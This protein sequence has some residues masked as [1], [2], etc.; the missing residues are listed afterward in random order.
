MASNQEQEQQQQQPPAP[1]P[2]TLPPATPETS[3]ASQELLHQMDQTEQQ[4]QAAIDA[5]KAQIEKERKEREA[6]RAE[7]EK[8]REEK[9]KEMEAWKAA[10]AETAVQTV[11]AMAK[12]LGKEELPKEVTDSLLNVYTSPQ[13]ASSHETFTALAS[14][15]SE[16]ERQKQ[17]LEQLKA[18]VAKLEAAQKSSEQFVQKTQASIMGLS[19][20][21]V[22]K[23]QAEKQLQ[24]NA[25]Q[26][27]I[28]TEASSSTF[29]SV[30]IRVPNPNADDYKLRGIEPGYNV[31]ASF[32][33]KEPFHVK[34]V[35]RKPRHGY[36]HIVPGSLAARPETAH[37]WNWVMNQDDGNLKN[38]GRF[39]SDPKDVQQFMQRDFKTPGSMGKM[40]W[41][42]KTN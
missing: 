30:F 33:G 19:Q 25:Q 4:S 36:E 28:A 27:T 10:Q 14:K 15:L 7:L 42:N 38:T 24:E 11:G 40:I 26:E 3:K 13:F 17:E 20:E 35:K 6:E 31:N 29:D 34:Q 5:L 16:A 39:V 12:A 2:A 8:Y 32:G 41:Y 37:V 23:Q 21:L 22:E 1:A 9:R 18:T